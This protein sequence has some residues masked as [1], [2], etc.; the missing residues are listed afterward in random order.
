MKTNRRRFLGQSS[1]VL[2]G[3]LPSLVSRAVVADDRALTDHD[4]KILVVIQMSG[5]ND[6]IN[7]I[8]PYADEGYAKH[9][10]KLR[11]P[12]DRLLK[13]D[14][15]IGFHPSMRSAADLLEQGKLGIVQGVGYPNPSRSHD[16]SMAIWHSARVGGEDVLRSHG[17]LGRT[18]D[19]ARNQADAPDMI[20]VG[21]EP[22]P[23]AI[24]S[25]RSTA[26]TLSDVTDLRL[27]VPQSEPSA[28]SGAATSLTR[29]VEQTMQNATATANVLERNIEKETDASA[30]YPSTKLGQRMQT[31]STMVKSGFQTPIY[32]AIQDG[33]DTHAAQ[34]PSHSRLL[35]EFSDATKAFLDDVEASGLS[36]RVCV[37]GFSEF[38]RR[39]AENNSEGTDHGTAGPVFLAGS[40][41]RSGLIGPTP[42][43]TDLV[44]GDLRMTTDFRNVYQEVER[45]WLGCKQGL[46]TPESASSLMLFDV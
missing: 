37:M 16:T 23:L 2:L 36:D 18:M 13:I 43:L 42:K 10:K 38:G 40:Q 6:G 14:D 22:Q 30:K 21:D 31:I 4:G 44:D 35:R 3:T 17:W 5:G 27:R 12:T 9:R 33:Y 24:Q 26:V 1:A 25:R 8:V 15:S 19:A 11:L 7:T 45:D 39:V 20:L 28:H 29:F 46:Q 34:L 41:V 32:Y